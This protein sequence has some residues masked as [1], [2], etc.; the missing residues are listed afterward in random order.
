[1]LL[2]VGERFGLRGKHI[3][4]LNAESLKDLSAQTVKAALKDVEQ[5][6]LTV[7]DGDFPR[8]VLSSRNLLFAEYKMPNRRNKPEVYD[9]TLKGPAGKKQGLLK[10]GSLQPLPAQQDQLSSIFQLFGARSSWSLGSLATMMFLAA[11]W[12]RRS[13]VV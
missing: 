12:F 8:E 2:R 1:E 11:L 13:R 3:D 6:T 10:L 5:I 7:V 9:A 4:Q